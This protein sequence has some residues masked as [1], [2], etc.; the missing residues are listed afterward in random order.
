MNLNIVQDL[1]VLRQALREQLRMRGVWKLA[2]EI[3]LGRSSNR[4]APSKQ[5]EVLTAE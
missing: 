4:G 3:S 2:I 1:M 5:E